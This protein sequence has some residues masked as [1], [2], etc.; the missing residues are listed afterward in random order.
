MDKKSNYKRIRILIFGKS[1]CA[2]CQTTKN[3]INHFIKKWELENKIEIIYWDMDTI[4]G[5]AEGAY[6]DIW[7]IPG[8]IIETEG[9]VVKRIIGAIPNSEDIYETIKKINC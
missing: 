7:E 9:R 3:K 8:I 5:R 1:N 2:K 6:Y 4:D